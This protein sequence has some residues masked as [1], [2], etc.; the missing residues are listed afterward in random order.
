MFNDATSSTPSSVT[1]V[2]EQGEET[3]I[4]QL[5]GNFDDH[6]EY[7]YFGGANEGLTV[8]MNTDICNTAV[9]TKPQF[10]P[11]DES[12]T[13]EDVQADEV[14]YE[15]GMTGNDGEAIVEDMDG[16]ELE[17]SPVELDIKPALENALKETKDSSEEK[18][19]V[20]TRRRDLLHDN[21]SSSSLPDK[22]ISNGPQG[23]ARLPSLNSSKA[24]DVKARLREEFAKAKSVGRR[25]RKLQSGIFALACTGAYCQVSCMICCMAFGL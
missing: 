8:M 3:S 2:D 15:S 5:D 13:V 18:D 12:G 6:G 4:L 17:D 1:F 21:S 20:F 22:S 24:N 16:E 25:D 23:M 19:D 11:Q 9:D 7:L 10:A 14:E